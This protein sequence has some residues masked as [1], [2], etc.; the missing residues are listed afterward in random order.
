M[1]E[2]GFDNI[3]VKKRVAKLFWIVGPC[4]KTGTG[5]AVWGSNARQPFN[6]DF[7]GIGVADRA[8]VRLL[9]TG[10]ANQGSE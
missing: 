3:F 7:D 4:V 5:Q 2:A 8:G 1:I 10:P 9:E 6:V